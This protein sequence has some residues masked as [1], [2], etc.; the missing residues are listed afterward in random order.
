MNDATNRFLN[1]NVVANGKPLQVH[2]PKDK[3]TLSDLDAR[4]KRNNSNE[5]NNNEKSTTGGSSTNF[6]QYLFGSGGSGDEISL[7][8]SINSSLASSSTNNDSPLLKF[9]NS[10]GR[11]DQN[12][13][14]NNSSESPSVQLSVSPTNELGTFEP[15]STNRMFNSMAK[16]LPPPEL[17]ART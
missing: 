5:T 4:L 10:S 14:N 12:I 13:N 7:S 3:L 15:E 8:S 17:I 6:R 9:H 11:H 1:A 2:T 16:N